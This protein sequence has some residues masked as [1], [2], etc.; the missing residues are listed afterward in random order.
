MFKMAKSNSTRIFSTHLIMKSL[1]ITDSG[2]YKCFKHK[3]DNEHLASYRLKVNLKKT[4]QN[5]HLNSEY[6]LIQPK[7]LRII[8]VVTSIALLSLINEAVK[9]YFQNKELKSL[10]ENKKKDCYGIQKF[11]KLNLEEYDKITKI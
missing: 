10:V 8:A 1:K 3:N 6:E 4:Q 9:I 7:L 2:I 5:T 11:L